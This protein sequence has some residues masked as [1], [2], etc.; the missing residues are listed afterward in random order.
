MS[1]P[2]D[3]YLAVKGVR[4]NKKKNSVR[5][6]NKEHVWDLCIDTILFNAIMHGTVNTGLIGFE[7]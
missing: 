1:T 6:K 7:I 3:V 2:N 4:K 5:H